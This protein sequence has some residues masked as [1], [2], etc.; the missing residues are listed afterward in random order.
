MKMLFTATIIERFS[1]PTVY[2][3]FDNYLYADSDEQ[4]DSGRWRWNPADVSVETASE[5][6]GETTFNAARRE[7][8]EAY[9]QYM[10]NQVV[11]G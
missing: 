1:E 7:V 6:W 5:R 2:V 3:F 4:G 8:Q 10:A 11:E 9:R